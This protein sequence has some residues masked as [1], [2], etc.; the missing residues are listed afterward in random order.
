[1]IIIWIFVSII[2]FSIIVIIHEWWHFAAARKFWVRVEE[3]WLWIPPRAKKLFVDKKW[4]LFSLNW[5]PIGWFVKLTWEMPNTFLAYNK[6]WKLYN[7][8]NLENDIIKW[9]DIF[10][11]NWKVAWKSDREEILQKLKENKADYNL[12]NKPS[13]QQA[14]IILAWVFMNFLLAAVIFSLLF[15]TW[16]KPIWIN[17]KIETDL[18]LKLI[19]T[20]EQAIESWLLIKNEWLILNPLEWSIAEKA[21]IKNWDI[22]KTINWKKINIPWKMIEIISD[23]KWKSIDFWIMQKTDCEEPNECLSYIPKNI[24]INIWNDWKIGSYI[25]ENIKLNENFE[26]NYWALDSIKYWISETYNQ[27]FLTFKWL[28]ILIRKI[29]NPETPV[30]RQEAIDQVSWPIWIVDFISNSLEAWFVFLLVIWAIISINL[31]VFNLLPIPALDWW[32]FIFITINWLIKK[33]FWKKAISEKT[34]WIIHVWFFVF[35]IALSLLIAYNDISK[36]ILR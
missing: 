22:L 14:I 30:E 26:Y 32:R 23:N 16:I 34:E 9:L 33:I 36:I 7:N 8:V 29:F 4:T 6:E 19:P 3:F 11:K 21:G 10:D 1:M 18:N 12:M 27:I 20:Y 24:L 2:L 15:F 5:L 25:S 17:T 28:W 35:L 13:W 31:W